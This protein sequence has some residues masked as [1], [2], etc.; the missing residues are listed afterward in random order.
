MQKIK[1]SIV[2]YLNSK[3]F[4]YGLKQGNLLS[5]MELTEDIPSVCAQK[6]MNGEIDLGLIP[7]AIIPLLK[8]HRIVSDYCIGAKGKVASVMLYS[9]VPLN[10][11]TTILLDYQS[12]T[13]VTLVKV[14]AN[15]FWKINPNWQSVSFDFENKIENT[16][17]AVVIGDRTF[18]MNNNY[19]YEYDLA[20]EWF[21][22]TGLPFVFAAWV[23]NKKL[24]LDFI[25]KFNYALSVGLANKKILIE[26]L[27]KEATYTI[28]IEHYLTQNIQ[29]ELDEEKK[30]GLNLF[31]DHL[32]KLDSLEA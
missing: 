4:V 25:S 16:T 5:E 7:V 23:A 1:V 22:F 21:K 12:R 14:L 27:K 32:K 24:P 8:E 6:L 18:E 15:N 17:A 10:E 29:Y 11:I 28:D 9:Q 31:L 30:I 13:S 26:Q 20:E 2:S 19:A 3:P